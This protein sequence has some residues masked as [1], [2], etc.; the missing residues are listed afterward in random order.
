MFPDFK[1]KTV[2]YKSSNRISKKI[3]SQIHNDLNY[4]EM[5]L[6]TLEESNDVN[7]YT[8]L[9]VFARYTRMSGNI[10]EEEVIKLIT[11]K[12]KW[13]GINIFT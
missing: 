2:D 7:V 1:E 9:A 13:T 8:Q 10:M 4:T 3:V 12:G 5:Y 6:V 11:L